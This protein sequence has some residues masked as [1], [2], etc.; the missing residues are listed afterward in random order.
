MLRLR[1][2]SGVREFLTTGAI[3]GRLDG[4]MPCLYL[5]ILVV[6]DWSLALVVFALGFLQVVVPAAS[7]S[8]TRQLM[9]VSLEAESRSGSYVYQLLAGIEALKAAGAEQ[10]SVERWSN[11]FA[12]EINA[13]LA[14]GR[15]NATVD[16][17]MSGLRMASPLAVLAF[18]TAQVLAGNLSLGAMLALSVL[19]VGFLEPLTQLVTTGTQLQLL[20]SYMARINDVLD[21][22]REQHGVDVV[23][24]NALTGHI[25]ARSISFR[26]SPL[27]PLVVT[28]VSLTIVAGQRVAIVG[29]SGSGKSTLAH[30][31]LG[32]Y[33]PDSGE[34]LYDGADLKGLE[35]HSVRQQIGIVTQAAYLFGSTIRE[36]IALVE[37]SAKLEDVQRAARLACIHDDVVSMPMGYETVLADGGASLSG[38]QRQRVAIAR[39][40]V[41][42]PRIVLLDEAT[43]ALDAIT[44]RQVYR[45]LRI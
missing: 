44:E 33:V 6:L 9:A 10:R 28:D 8:R 23:A 27:A 21:T 41:R 26:Y 29:R 24:A 36:N 16:A 4:C 1:S 7:A 18:G 45:N 37:P 42:L 34:V 31:L 11:L 32:L 38:G 17:V 14:R 15:L 22:P 12:A 5:V 19:A 40:L 35:A 20:S 30:L 43:S 3:S 39:A 13:S 2:N 25:Q